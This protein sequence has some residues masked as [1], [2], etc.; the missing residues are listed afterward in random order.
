[1][2]AARWAR[3][4]C[5]WCTR[6]RRRSRGNF[7]SAQP[8]EE[9]RRAVLLAVARRW[10]RSDRPA[11]GHSRRPGG[12]SDRWCRCRCRCS[13]TVGVVALAVEAA[14]VH[15]TGIEEEALGVDATGEDRPRRDEDSKDGGEEP[16]QPTRRCHPRQAWGIGSIERGVDPEPLIVRPVLH[17]AR[18][19]TMRTP[20]WSHTPAVRR[21]DA[22]HTVKAGAL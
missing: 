12:R 8:S 11:R 13:S 9:V 17:P 21:E 7:P 19:A 2:S 14:R 10:R 6:R 3:R 20:A 18:A 4:S 22:L 15:Q 5:R 1:M 16:P